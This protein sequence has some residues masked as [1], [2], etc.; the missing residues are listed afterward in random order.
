LA[1]EASRG[2]PLLEEPAAAEPDEPPAGVEPAA[3]PALPEPPAPEPEEPQPTEPDV[4]M[5]PPTLRLSLFYSGV[6]FAPQAP[7]SHG[8]GLG[9]RLDW[10]TGFFAAIGG[11]W[12]ALVKAP[13]PLVVQRVP[14]GAAIGYRLNVLK[15]LSADLELGLLVELLFRSTRGTGSGQTDGLRVMPTLAPRLRAEY[16]PMELLGFFVGLGPD[17]ALTRP[18]YR[19]KTEAAQM[20]L[21]PRLVRP[22]MEAGV[23]FYQ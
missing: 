22:A 23:A 6:D 10:Q 1:R 14:L 7:F 9:A 15:N 18:T 3:P 16:R 21:S 19:A 4:P 17:V 13:G 12:A 2:G 8:V 5:P 20:L 11:T